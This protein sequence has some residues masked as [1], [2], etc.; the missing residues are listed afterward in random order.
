MAEETATQT[1]EP[2]QQTEEVPKSHL[3]GD[4]DWNK[5]ENYPGFEKLAP[6]TQE[7]FKETLRKQQANWTRKYQEVSNNKPRYG[8]STAEEALKDP[9]F[10]AELQNIS[11][12]EEQVNQAVKSGAEYMDQMVQATVGGQ[13]NE[14]QI[15]NY[16][17]TLTPPERI[18]FTTAVEQK[19]Q[20]KRNHEETL[21]RMD[22]QNLEKYGDRYK[23]LK[24]KFPDIYQSAAKNPQEVAFKVLDYD[25][26]YKRGYEAGLKEQ[27]ASRSG[28]QSTSGIGESTNTRSETTRPSNPAEAMITSLR[29]AGWTDAQMKDHFG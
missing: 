18:T 8:F 3:G 23:E 5:A 24:S 1:A 19:V 10:R 29:E 14:T 28:L 4:G 2:T 21:G 16:L 25:A 17:A 15:R 20:A 6:E 9:T 27:N 13:V 11:A 22:S 7:A 26:N 12:Q